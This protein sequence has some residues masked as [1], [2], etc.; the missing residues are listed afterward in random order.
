MGNDY[1]NALEQGRNGSEVI[2]DTTPHDGVW[3]GFLVLNDAVISSITEDNCTNPEG[4]E[5][6]TI[7]AGLYV[8]GQI[9][10][11]TLTSGVVKM[12]N[13]YAY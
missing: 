6:I 2:D 3:G 9:N 1:N 5:S 10:S 11:I 8:P 12:Y 7:G 4:Q 13:R